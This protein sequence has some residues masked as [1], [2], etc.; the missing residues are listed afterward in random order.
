ML[1]GDFGAEID[2]KI[3]GVSKWMSNFRRCA[4]W[5]VPSF[6]SDLKDVP[7]ETQCLIYEKV[8]GK[9]GVIVPL[10]TKQYKCVLSGGENGLYAR[11]SSYYD[12][13]HSCTGYAFVYA[14]GRKPV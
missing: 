8:D 11:L 5:C 14:G 1:C 2:I 9:C 4:F 6:G 13:L 12:L 10:V 7:D 3:D